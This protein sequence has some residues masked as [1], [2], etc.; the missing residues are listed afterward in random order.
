MYH[1]ALEKESEWDCGGG[2]AAH[3]DNGL[4]DFHSVYEFSSTNSWP[5][6]QVLSA[7]D[8]KLGVARMRSEARPAA[9]GTINRAAEG[10]SRKEKEREK[11][12]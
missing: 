1:V 10:M 9:P 8:G 6:F 11:R 4:F 3:F 2:L 5:F 7:G 12:R